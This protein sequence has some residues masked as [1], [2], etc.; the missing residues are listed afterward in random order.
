MARMDDGLISL[1]IEGASEDEL[2]RGLAAARRH[3]ARSGLYVD[4]A[5]QSAERREQYDQGIAAWQAG[6]AA[7]P[8]EE[9]GEEDLDRADVVEE[10]WIAGLQAAGFPFGV[11]GLLPPD[12]RPAPA[13]RDLFAE[14][15]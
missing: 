8:P 9:P 3:I 10:A 15:C 7:I 14:I 4:E 12:R 11:L 5:M 13:V 2:R 1:E 6:Q